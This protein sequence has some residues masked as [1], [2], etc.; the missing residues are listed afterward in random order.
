MRGPVVVEGSVPT[1]SYE[2]RGGVAEWGSTRYAVRVG[3]GGNGRLGNDGGTDDGG[4]GSSRGGRVGANAQLSEEGLGEGSGLGRSW[5]KATARGEK[6]VKKRRSCGGGAGARGGGRASGRA[7]TYADASCLKLA[8]GFLQ[9]WKRLPH[10][11]PCGRA[12]GA[13]AG[14]QGC[15]G[16]RVQRR[17]S[18]LY[19]KLADCLCELGNECLVYAPLDVEPVGAHARLARVPELGCHCAR[20]CRWEGYRE[21]GERVKLVLWPSSHRSH[22]TLDCRGADTGRGVRHTHV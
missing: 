20:N 15:K 14:G 11:R 8:D 7:G 5:M 13:W 1:P 2:G 3:G 19:L 9:T 17:R 12:G 21:G 10:A 16:A 22:D 4:G 18:A 6:G